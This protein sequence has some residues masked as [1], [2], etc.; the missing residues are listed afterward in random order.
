MK[1]GFSTGFD[2]SDT[3]ELAGILTERPSLAVAV[4]LKAIFAGLHKGIEDG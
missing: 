1:K 2:V 3:M 4:V